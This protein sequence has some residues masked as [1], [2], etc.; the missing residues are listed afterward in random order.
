MKALSTMLRLN[1][2]SLTS[3]A[4]RARRQIYRP[5]KV[6][7]PPEPMYTSHIV[8]RRSIGGFRSYSVTPRRVRPQTTVLYFYG[9]AYVSEISAQH[10]AF[11]AQLADAGMRVEVPMYGLAPSVHHCGVSAIGDRTPRVA[12]RT[13]RR[14]RRRWS[15]VA[16][17]TDRA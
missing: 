9:G 4:E 5:K 11:I 3:T 10:W 12:H 7:S 15:G 17:G 2:L 1:G 14:F 6:V 13:G 16:D 8:K